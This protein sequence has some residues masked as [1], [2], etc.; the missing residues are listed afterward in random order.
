MLSTFLALLASA[1]AR[2]FGPDGLHFRPSIAPPDW[3][4]RGF[5]TLPPLARRPTPWLTL[6]R[7]DPRGAHW[8]IEVALSKIECIVPFLTEKLCHG[9]ALDI[10]RSEIRGAG[11]P[12]DSRRRRHTYDAYYATWVAPNHLAPAI[13]PVDKAKAPHEQADT[14]PSETRPVL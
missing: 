12:L 2:E 3:P 10:E 8:E 9:S 4:S 1:L 6:P 5:L 13:H 11:S 7:A 14:R